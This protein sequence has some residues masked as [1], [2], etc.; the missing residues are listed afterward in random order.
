[1]EI[2][3][4]GV[5]KNGTN[6]STIS[7][8]Q[9]ASNAFAKV[10]D[11]SESLAY[12]LAISEATI[13][14]LDT[15]SQACIDNGKAVPVQITYMK[16]Y[17]KIMKEL[18]DKTAKATGGMI[19]NDELKDAIEKDVFVE[20]KKELGIKDLSSDIGK[21]FNKELAKSESENEHLL[22]VQKVLASIHNGVMAYEKKYKNK[23]TD[24]GKKNLLY[25]KLGFVTAMAGSNFLD[26]FLKDKEMMPVA[27]DVIK[28]VGASAWSVIY[29][30]ASE[31]IPEF[32]AKHP[33]SSQYVSN[34]SNGAT[35]AFA[36]FELGKTIGNKAIP[37]IFEWLLNP[38]YVSAGIENKQISLYPLRTKVQFVTEQYEVIW[39]S[40]KKTMAEHTPDTVYLSQNDKIKVFVYAQQ[41]YLWDSERSPWYLESF[42]PRQSLYS[43][44]IYYH[45]NKAVYLKN[46][47]TESLEYFDS[48]LDSGITTG[49]PMI[50]QSRYLGADATNTENKDCSKSSAFVG[51]D[52]YRY[53]S[54]FTTLWL[55]SFINTSDRQITIK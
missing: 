23:L 4:D 45:D 29:E 38:N 44:S 14:I 30:N 48:Y 18:I 34:I 47:V 53:V 10:K 5:V 35:K 25:A 21:D 33:S 50:S 39:D 13:E 19:S 46:C 2:G 36:G 40:S 28:D 31:K 16:N 12:Y 42:L 24:S 11:I 43:A 7:I 32:I 8:A 26:A 3:L 27:I 41:E 6:S 54:S 9:R 17:H 20:Y 37:F 55:P 1:L 15:F 51:H 52:R 22:A 49:T